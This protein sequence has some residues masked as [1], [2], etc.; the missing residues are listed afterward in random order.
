M[1]ILLSVLVLVLTGRWLYQHQTVSQTAVTDSTWLAIQNWPAPAD[2]ALGPWPST[3]QKSAFYRKE[4]ALAGVLFPFDPNTLDAAGWKRLGIRDRTITGILHYREKGGRF[5]RAD[6]IRKIWGIP[7]DMRERLI[8]YVCIAIDAAPPEQ[9]GYPTPVFRKPPPAAP[10]VIDINQ[11]DSA[12]WEALPGIGPSLASRIIRFREKLGGFYS[13]DQVAETFGLPDSV[14]RLIVPR[15]QLRQTSVQQLA[16]NES[17]VSVLAA[18]PYIRF[19]L[20]RLIVSYRLQHG[21]FKTPRDLLMIPACNDSLIQKLA[22]Y[23]KF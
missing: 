20:A 7:P 21:N 13:I 23:L 5:R 8:P 16:I 10:V 17:D 3:H 6:D 12:A 15:L 14:F 1:A 4:H 18:H 2:S 22:P 11:A 19:K 9:S